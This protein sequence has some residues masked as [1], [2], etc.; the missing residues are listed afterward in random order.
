M[1]SKSFAAFILLVLASSVNADFVAEPAMGVSGTPVAGDVQHPSTGN[2]CGTPSIPQNIDS[3]SCVQAD[4][5][6]HQEKPHLPIS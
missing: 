2:P 3:S 6:G 5:D 1:L 4:T